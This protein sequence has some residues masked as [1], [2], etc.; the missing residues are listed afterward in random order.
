[1]TTIEAGPRKASLVNKLTRGVR[2]SNLRDYAIVFTCAALFVTLS[3][4]SSSFFTT[5]NL[6]NIL[7]QSAAL[8]IIACGGTVVFIAGGFDLSV[9]AVFGMAG[10]V[11]AMLDPYLGAGAALTTGLLLGI[12]I[13][14]LNG[15]VVTVG[16]IN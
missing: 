5:T 14:V 15:L 2:F 9:G 16:R 8:G 12:G 10:V 1:M 3:L 6:L 7:D 11:S 4:S 13:G